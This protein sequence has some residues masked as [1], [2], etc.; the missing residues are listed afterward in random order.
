M[1]NNKQKK[2]VDKISLSR[3]RYHFSPEDYPQVCEFKIFF[4]DTL[5]LS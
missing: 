5:M 1:M 3:C 2:S 4:V